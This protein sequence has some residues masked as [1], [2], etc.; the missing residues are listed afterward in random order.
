MIMK[1][2]FIFVDVVSENLSGKKLNGRDQMI[3]LT[4]QLLFCASDYQLTFNTIVQ[5][6]GG[7]QLYRGI[8]FVAVGSCGAP[9]VP[10]VNKY[11]LIYSWFY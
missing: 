2:D 1:Y 3:V 8:K 10:P 4:E 6:S 11:I 9:P 5:H 7:L